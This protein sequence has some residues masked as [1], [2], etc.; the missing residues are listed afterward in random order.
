[1]EG[2]KN[3]TYLH[4]NKSTVPKR[5]HINWNI[6]ILYTIVIISFSSANIYLFILILMYTRIE[7]VCELHSITEQFICG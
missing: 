1:M 3:K 6:H 7:F 2:Y 4:A 5:F